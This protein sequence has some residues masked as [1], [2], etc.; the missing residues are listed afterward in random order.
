[1]KLQLAHKDEMNKPTIQ[2][3]NIRVICTG[4]EIVIME[5]SYLIGCSFIESFHIQWAQSTVWV[6]ITS[7]Y[8]LHLFWNDITNAIERSLNKKTGVW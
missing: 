6:G 8:A 3:D 2:I 1:M 5:I 4:I 7:E